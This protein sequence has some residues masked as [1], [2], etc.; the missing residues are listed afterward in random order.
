MRRAAALLI[1]YSLG[2]PAFSASNYD[3][4][5]DRNNSPSYSDNSFD[6]NQ[7]M[8]AHRVASFAHQTYSI[9]MRSPIQIPRINLDFTFYTTFTRP[10]LDLGFTSFSE[11]RFK[12]CPVVKID[13]NFLTLINLKTTDAVQIRR[14]T[15]TT[16]F[17]NDTVSSNVSDSVLSLNKNLDLSFDLK[18]RAITPPQQTA[19]AS[20]SPKARLLDFVPPAL[21]RFYG[22]ADHQ[23]P[24]ASQ[25]LDATNSHRGS[26]PTR[27]FDAVATAIKAVPAFINGVGQKIAV[28]GKAVWNRVVL[29][30]RTVQSFKLPDG[31]TLEGK[32][33]F[34][35]KDAFVSVAPGTIRTVGEVQ[36]TQTGPTLVPSKTPLKIND[37]EY[38][39]GKFVSNGMIY[40][41]SGPG[42]RLSKEA[43]PNIE[44][45]A[46][47]KVFVNGDGQGGETILG[48]GSLSLYSEKKWSDRLVE[49]QV[50]GVN[51]NE[52]TKHLIRAQKALGG[53]GSIGDILLFP[54][55]W[56][57]R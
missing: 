4:N 40:N 35:R 9:R 36:N 17:R 23:T 31:S 5:N 18:T 12:A 47:F 43:R 15:P 24:V 57:L 13:Q 34:N 21:G 46:P 10:Q 52:I 28:L 55:N 14:Q 39:Q 50:D 44:T 37:Q 49:C 3:Y 42:I 33:T 29:G 41:L 32:I 2:A 53:M 30:H 11:P 1:S 56:H 27:L 38:T 19:L 51:D 26:A 8:A 22:I 48:L 20:Q 54:E 45:S 7:Q 25:R 16:S 6:R